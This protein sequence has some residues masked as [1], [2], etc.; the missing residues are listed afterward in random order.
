MRVDDLNELCVCDTAKETG[1]RERH[2][3][4]GRVDKNGLCENE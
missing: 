2:L 4:G 3:T 1:V